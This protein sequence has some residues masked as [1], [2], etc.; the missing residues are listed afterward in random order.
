MKMKTYKFESVH[1]MK[2]RFKFRISLLQRS[3][4][5][6][7]SMLA[8]PEEP[9]HDDQPVGGTVL[10]RLQAQGTPQMHRWPS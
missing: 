10:D 1:I 9:D 7:I 2:Y 8:E 4:Q 6:L 3:Y 5:S